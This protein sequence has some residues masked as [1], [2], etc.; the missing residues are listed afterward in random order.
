M[1]RRRR[2]WVLRLTSGEVGLK[3]PVVSQL[4]L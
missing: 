2:R 4:I 1:T 3:L